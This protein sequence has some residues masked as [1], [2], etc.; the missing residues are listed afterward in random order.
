MHSLNIFSGYCKKW[1]LQINYDKTKILVFGDRTII[2]NYLNIDNHAIEIV[3][4]FNFLCVM[5]LKKGTF[6]S[7]MFGLFRTKRNLNLSIECQLKL[8]DH[9]VVPVLL[10]GCEIWGFGDLSS[11]EKVNTD[12]MKY[13]LHVKKVPLM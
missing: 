6:N 1:K 5:F 10:Y 13:K 7:A 12:F 9:T 2:Y 8:F 11:V 4:E 3:G